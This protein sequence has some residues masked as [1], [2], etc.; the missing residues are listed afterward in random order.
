MKNC[1]TNERTVVG[2][3]ALLILFSGKLSAQS[4]ILG[5]TYGGSFNGHSYYVS[6]CMTTWQQAQDAATQM[7]GYLVTITSEAENDFISEF[8]PAMN[9]PSSS[10][11]EVE[12]GAWTGMLSMY[13]N[14]ICNFWEWLNGEQIVYTNWPNCVLE[15]E[16]Q[17]G[18]TLIVGI[19][20]GDGACLWPFE[21]EWRTAWYDGG[22]PR[23][24]IVE[25][26]S[27]PGCSNP[28]KTHVCH[29][30]IT[31]CVSQSSLQSH[32]NHGDYEG[33]CGNPCNANAISAP[34][35][36]EN[37][38][39]SN[40]SYVPFNSELE[41]RDV[42]HIFPNPA[43]N[44]IQVDLGHVLKQATMGIY[45]ATGEKVY[46]H[47]FQNENTAIIDVSSLPTG[48]ML[49]EVRSGGQIVMKKVVK[50]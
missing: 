21:F 23:K 14:G 43:T 9:A 12:Y 41:D 16:T 46:E 24:Y 13:N 32:L 48:I 39:I 47:T 18:S 40:E 28:E 2:L 36:F 33:P 34:H 29:N 44:Q 20:Y 50:L 49:V 5:H 31:I 38:D 22:W 30:G 17:C 3:L 35:D 19:C 7:G 10:D 27:D 26:D 25:F 8:A 15:P 45:L 42:V 6:D 37:A 1:T 11:E 4:E